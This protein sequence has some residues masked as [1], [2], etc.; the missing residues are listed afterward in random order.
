[1]SAVL[2]LIRPTKKSENAEDIRDYTTYGDRCCKRYNQKLNGISGPVEQ[3]AYAQGW[4]LRPRF[5]NRKCTMFVADTKKGMM[6]FFNRY[7]K[8]EDGVYMRYDEGG[9][10]TRCTRDNRLHDTIKQFESAWNEGCIFIVSF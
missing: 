4:F 5:F 7:G 8:H 6:D 10:L 3:V 1:M 9:Y 2:E